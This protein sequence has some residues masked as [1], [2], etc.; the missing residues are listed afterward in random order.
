MDCIVYIDGM[1]ELI[2][3]FQV[4]VFYYYGCIDIV[5]DDDYLDQSVMQVDGEVWCKEFEGF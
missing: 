4:D 2:D 3:F 5:V 1:I